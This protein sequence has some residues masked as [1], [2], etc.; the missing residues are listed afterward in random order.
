MILQGIRHNYI[1]IPNLKEYNIKH[2]LSYFV[3]YILDNLLRKIYWLIRPTR[4]LQK[5]KI[6]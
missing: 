2:D 6:N 5:V 4:Y 3:D 1:L